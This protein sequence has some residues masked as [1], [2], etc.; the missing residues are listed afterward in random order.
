V[1]DGR[2]E[3]RSLLGEGGMGTVFAGVQTSLERPVAIKVLRPEVAGSEDVIKRFAREA[4]LTARLSHPNT[5]KL[6]DYGRTE[7]GQVYLVMELLQ[8]EELADLISK[9]G[10][11]PVHRALRVARQVACALR[12]GHRLGIVHRDLKPSN[13][14]ITTG[15]DGGDHAT[16]LD[17]GFAKKLDESVSQR[18]TAYGTVLG[19]PAYMAPEQAEGQPVS[20]ACDVYALGVVL[21]EM[22]TGQAPFADKSMLTVLMM[23]KTK[24]P[25]DLAEVRP[26]LAAAVEVQKLLDTLLDKRPEARPD[27]DHLIARFDELLVGAPPPARPAPSRITVDGAGESEATAFAQ[28]ID[29]ITLDGDKPVVVPAASKPPSS[30]LRVETARQHGR[31]SVEFGATAAA[32]ETAIDR[33]AL[34]DS[35]PPKATPAK[36]ISKPAKR[37]AVATT[38][39]PAPRPKSNKAVAKGRMPRSRAQVNRDVARVVEPPTVTPGPAP[40]PET[41]VVPVPAASD[42]GSGGGSSWLGVGIGVAVLAVLLGAGLAVVGVGGEDETPRTDEVAGSDKAPARDEDPGAAASAGPDE[43][44]Q[45][46]EAAG[47]DEPAKADEPAKTDEPAKADEAS[48]PG[49]TAEAGN[50]AE[51]DKPAAADT[52]PEAERPAAGKVRVT[53][54]PTGAKVYVNRKK[55]GKTPMVLELPQRKRRSRIAMRLRGH[56]TWGLWVNKDRREA[57]HAVLVSRRKK[58]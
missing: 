31:K 38:S 13:V 47:T 30:R 10:P 9:Q 3:V 22:L 5:I 20:P 8:G 21:F 18:L 32:D 2:Y 1:L 28:A 35:G 36:R 54:E 42:Q 24:P 17:F 37:P 46:D 16:V 12:A 41:A 55:I 34:R 49:K 14:R 45:A 11:L 58:R 57:V 52:S 25:P 29:D 40:H 48:E 43:G 27:A 44:P 15:D 26:E 4:K 39:K 7:A 19:T 6:F 53:S 56:K 33:R 50:G 23:Q 51:A